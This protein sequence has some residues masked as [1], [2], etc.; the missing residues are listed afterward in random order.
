MLP[1]ALDTECLAVCANS[2]DELVICDIH[3]RTL[4]HLRRLNS[5]IPALGVFGG[6][7]D[8]LA[9]KVIGLVLLHA[10]DLAREVYVVRP[11]LV[12]FDIS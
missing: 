3:H 9:G 6:R 10:D 7:Q 4:G 5:D 1:H 8:G 12:K 11:S 2:N